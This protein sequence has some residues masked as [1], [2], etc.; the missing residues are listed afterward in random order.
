MNKS[1]VR[2]RA[3]S[4]VQILERQSRARLTSKSLGDERSLRSWLVRRRITW[5][6]EWK[7][8]ETAR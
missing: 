4:V 3:R 8:R 1:G 5:V 2:S 6:E 7:E